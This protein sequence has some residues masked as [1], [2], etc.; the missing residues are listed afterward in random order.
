MTHSPHKTFLILKFINALI[1]LH[2]QRI[3]LM[4]IIRL[5]LLKFILI[6]RQHLIILLQVI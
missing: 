5:S 4:K 6:L 3:G 1:R 2:H